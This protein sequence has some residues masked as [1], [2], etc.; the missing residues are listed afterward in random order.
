M[1]LASLL[2]CIGIVTPM[3]GF[4]QTKPGNAALAGASSGPFRAS[5]CFAFS[6]SSTRQRYTEVRGKIRK[7]QFYSEHDEQL[8]DF[9]LTPHSQPSDTAQL[10]LKLVNGIDGPFCHSPAPL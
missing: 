1:K 10:V 4:I 9:C 7:S 3:F 5:H 6:P 2:S 8:F